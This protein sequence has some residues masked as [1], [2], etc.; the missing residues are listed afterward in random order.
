VDTKVLE[1][2]AASIF[3]VEVSVFTMQLGFIG[4]FQGRQ[5]LTSM[6]ALRKNV[7]AYFPLFEK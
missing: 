4:N 5:S 2:Y 7:S 1:E 3:R 6:G